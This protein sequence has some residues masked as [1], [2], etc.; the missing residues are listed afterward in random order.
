DGDDGPW[1]SF[2][3]Q[4]GT[5][6]QRSRLFAS[7]RS[8]SFWVPVP[9]G[10]TK[11]DPDDCGE[12]RGF[13]FNTGSSTSWESKGLYELETYE[14]AKLGLSGNGLY[15]FDSVTIGWP[16]DNGP[17]VSN[18]AIAGIATKDFYLGG[19]PLTPWATNFTDIQNPFPSFL[20]TLK[21]NGSIPSISWGYTAGAYYN[22]PQVFGS[23]ILGGYD[24]ARIDPTKQQVSLSLGSDVSREHL[25][26][27]QN[28]TF[29]SGSSPQNLAAASDGI[30]ANINTNV[31]GMWLPKPV[32]DRFA[33]AF[34]ITFDNRTDLYLINDTQHETLKQ[35]NPSV[36][37]QLG[38]SLIDALSTDIVLPYSSLALQAKSPFLKG[39]AGSEAR[40]LPIHVA[41]NNTAY[42]LGRVLLQHAYVFTDYERM[43]FT[44]A[45][46][47]LPGATNPTAEIVPI[48]VP[49]YVTTTKS[50]SLGGGAIAGIVI[51]VVAAITGVALVFWFMY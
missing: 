23:L 9:E 2:S 35:S 1:S 16:G 38:G 17:T 50:S 40:Y 7:T 41:P 33:E 39:S 13:L 31:G 30:F 49:G 11:D 21:D 44:V 34:G 12:N 27:V 5:P 10:C 6:P 24:L 36:T 15:G 20:T 29:T 32:C 51:G 45:P 37:M 4:I 14:E 43:N 8:T 48:R 46:A 25:I 19:I 18:Q 3:I 26:A 28:I 42:T 47:L 22:A